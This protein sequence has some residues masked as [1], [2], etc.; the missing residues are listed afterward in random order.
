MAHYGL[1][2]PSRKHVTEMHQMVHSR[3]HDGPLELAK[4]YEDEL[5][6]GKFLDRLSPEVKNGNT[7]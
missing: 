5:S 7:G 1:G 6:Y 4:Y 2:T 3:Q